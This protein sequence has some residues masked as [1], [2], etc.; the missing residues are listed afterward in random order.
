MSSIKFISVCAIFALVVT[1]NIASKILAIVPTATYSHQLAFRNVWI[2]LANRG[3]QVTLLT[4][5]PMN[6]PDLKNLREID[7]G[8][9]S[10]IVEDYIELI[11]K[12]PESKAFKLMTSSFDDTMRH[13]LSLEPVRNLIHNESGFD[14]VITE[15][16][17]YEFLAFADLYKCPRVLVSSFQP[18]NFVLSVLGNP[19]SPA[20]PTIE[21]SILTG[22]VGNTFYIR[23]KGFMMSLLYL[24]FKWVEHLPLRHEI[25]KEA[26]GPNVRRP[27]EILRDTDLLLIS[28]SPIITGITSVGPNI[29]HI[30]DGL[31]N[32]PP[33]PLPKDLQ[34]FLDSATEG[35]IY[36]SLGTNSKGTYLP[37]EEIQLFLDTFKELPYKVL[38]KF[39]NVDMIKPPKNVKL[40]P[41]LPQ[42]D[43]L[44][45]PNVKLFIMQGGLQ[46]LEESILSRV[47]MLIIPGWYTDQKANAMQMELKG[48]ARIVHHKPLPSKEYLTEVINDVITNPK[49]IDNVNKIADLITDQPMK[50]VD[51]AVWWI[52]YVLRHKGAKHLRHPAIDIPFYQYYCLDSISVVIGIVVSVCAILIW[53]AKKILRAVV[54]ILHKSTPTVNKKKV[55]TKRSKKDS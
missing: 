5:H 23:F 10:K 43:V 51:K 25:L 32:F 26:F 15:S 37:P 13:Q 9:S 24:L 22:Q 4:T 7:T 47:P 3:H 27:T 34:K 46:S 45:H 18:L 52:E 17:A 30:G 19:T 16:I 33:K 38:W 12:S 41:W 2:A 29:V 48:V 39:E 49:Y 28:S 11:H 55:T 50:G 36:F 8:S 20:I 44:R 21:I 53:I 35:C 31:H 40:M 14:L 6:N 54:G 1:P 42:Q